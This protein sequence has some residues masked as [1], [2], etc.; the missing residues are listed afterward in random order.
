MLSKNIL[1]IS[2][3]IG[4]IQGSRNGKNSLILIKAIYKNLTA[5]I[6]LKG[7]ILLKRRD[8]MALSVLTASIRHFTG[9]LVRAIRQGKAI[10][11]IQI[12]ME[13]AKL[14]LFTDSIT[15]HIENSKECS[16]TENY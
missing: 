2:N 5:H 10:K 16:H 15:M 3:M 6:I 14:P 12:G 11:S 13:K 1:T 7:R 8:Q 9:G 4:K